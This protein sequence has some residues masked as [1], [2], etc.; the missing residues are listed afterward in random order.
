MQIALKCEKCGN[1]FKETEEDLC[2]EIDFKE[3]TIS[4]ICRN[5]NCKYEN[6]IDFKPWQKQQKYSPLP[7]IATL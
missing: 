4:Y 1:I 5:K 7:K 3:R 2:L 6:I